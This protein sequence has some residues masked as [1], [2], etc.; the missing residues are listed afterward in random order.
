MDLISVPDST[1]PASIESSIEYS[2]RARRFRAIVFSGMGRGSWRSGVSLKART[3]VP[4]DRR[5]V[6]ADHPQWVTD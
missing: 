6:A 4:K 5:S 1:M 2:W 3:P